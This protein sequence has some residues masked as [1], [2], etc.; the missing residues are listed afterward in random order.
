[1]SGNA[2]HHNLIVIGSGHAGYT[3][4]KLWRKRNKDQSLLILTAD[5]GASYSKPM[6]SNGLAKNKSAA[7]LATQAA[8]KMA[9]TLEAA[10]VTHTQVTGIDA[11]LKQVRA[12]GVV[13]AYDSL[14]LACGAQQIELPIEGDRSDILTVNNLADYAKFL[15]KLD[16]VDRV[17]VMGP[18]LIGCEFANDLAAVG[19]S[20]VIIGPDTRALERLVPAVASAALSAAMQELPVEWH[21]ETV[22]Q[23]IEKLASGYRLQLASGLTV[24]A[25]LV[26]SAAG[27]KPDLQLA[28]TAG[29]ETAQGIVVDRTMRTSSPDI[30]ALGDCAEVEGM[31]LP[32]IMPIMHAAKALSLTLSGQP[33]E[34]TYPAMP[35]VI[36]TPAHPVVV[37]TPPPGVDGSWQIESEKEGVYAVF[38]DT[39]GLLQGF[40][41]TGAHI[42]A[43]GKLERQ[44]PALLPASSAGA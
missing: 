41:L 33:T 25:G 11:E 30:Y 39:Q 29:L 19:K 8:E 2:N 37:A 36:K 31:V 10:V 42:S 13:Y 6:L 23:R 12:A 7:D 44:L 9:E 17:A 14:V 26:L 24:E 32:Y 35:V 28:L 21:L 15:Q 20:T 16:G 38:N 5:D 22:V 4:A 40:V 18:G 1:M 43:K 34:V 3:L 27:L